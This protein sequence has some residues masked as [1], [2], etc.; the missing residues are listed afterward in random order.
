MK[1]QVQAP[2]GDQIGDPGV[3]G[4]WGHQGW[5]CDLHSGSLIEDPPRPS[6]PQVVYLS[7]P[8]MALRLMSFPPSCPHWAKFSPWALPQGLLPG[9][10]L[11]QLSFTVC[12]SRA[13]SEPRSPSTRRARPRTQHCVPEFSQ[14]RPGAATYHPHFSDGAGKPQGSQAT[15]SGAPSS[16]TGCRDSSPDLQAPTPYRRGVLRE[17]LGVSVR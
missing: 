13:R 12:L 14:Q 17:A 11:A 3:A 16:Q 10:P 2:R 7:H 15:R 1:S 9:A 6:E 5:H 8:Y 4:L